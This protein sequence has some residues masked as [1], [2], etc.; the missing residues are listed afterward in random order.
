L[1]FEK[2]NGYGL[3]NSIDGLWTVNAE[4]SPEVQRVEFYLDGDLKQN[5]TSAPI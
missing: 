2:N 1:S 4:L 5:D 3:G